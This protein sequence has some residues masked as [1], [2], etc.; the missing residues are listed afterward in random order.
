MIGEITGG[1]LKLSEGTISKWNKDLSKLVV[2]AIQKIKEKLL[3]SDVLHKDETGVWVDKKLRWFHVLSNAG[4]SFFYAHGKRGRDADIEAAVLPAF[5]GILVHDHLRSLYHFNCGHAECNAHILRYLKSAVENK[6]RRWAEE[7]IT[8]F[9]K[10]KSAVKAKLPD[11]EEIQNFHRLYDEI[12]YNGESEIQQN[13][14]PDYKG[15][16]LALLRRLREYKNQHL[17]FLSDKN[18]PF[19]NN[20]AERDLRMIKAKTKISGCFRSNDGDSI[21]AALK[22]YTASLRKNCLNIFAGLLSAWCGTPVLFLHGA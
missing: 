14:N 19:D 13:E 16:D 22:T 2:P 4:Y 18:V 17:L 12:L 7:M 6:K 11:S 3:K 5:K 8:F 10:A 1:V 15:A 20:Q 9:M 21:F